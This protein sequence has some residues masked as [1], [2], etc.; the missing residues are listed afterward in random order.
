MKQFLRALTVSQLEVVAALLF[1]NSLVLYVTFSV[2]NHDGY[3]ARYFSALQVSAPLSEQ[4]QVLS[5]QI[6][7]SN[8]AGNI[9]VFSFWGGVGLLAYYMIYYLFI[10]EREAAD[11]IRSLRK[12]GA[13]RVS[14]LEYE[15][16]VVGIR[17]GA[18]IAIL[19]AFVFFQRIILP[20]E[21]VVL[22]ISQFTPVFDRLVELSVAA[23][24]L[25]VLFHIV[26]VLLRCALLR[27]RVFF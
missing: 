27:V 18:S 12:R 7:S 20:Y 11:F 8:I 23:G 10:S 22:N 24:I 1:L 17:I 9:A 15:F 6:N 4:Y 13:D 5:T 21:L 14:L 26:V 19:F 2:L 25:L 16:A 3:I